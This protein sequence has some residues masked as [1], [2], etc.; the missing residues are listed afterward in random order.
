MAKTPRAT[1]QPFAVPPKGPASTP[2]LKRSGM[3]KLSPQVNNGKT[4]NLKY[5]GIND[6]GSLESANGAI[7]YTD[8]DSIQEVFAATVDFDRPDYN[9]T[10]SPMPNAGY[11]GT[12]HRIS[13]TNGVPK[14]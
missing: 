4:H 2:E 13:D 8:Y 5:S 7:A 1:A 11:D 9:I 14:R 10:K 6:S 3:T 12:S